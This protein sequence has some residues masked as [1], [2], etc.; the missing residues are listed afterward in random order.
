MTANAVEQMTRNMEARLSSLCVITSCQRRNDTT[1]FSW[2]WKNK[3]LLFFLFFFSNWFL[4]VATIYESSG[5]TFRLSIPSSCIF[6]ENTPRCHFLTLRYFSK[7]SM[8]HLKISFMQNVS[9][10]ISLVPKDPN[11]RRKAHV[12]IY[13][14]NFPLLFFFYVVREGKT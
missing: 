2:V 6:I 10:N 7:Q 12:P 4:I 13:L 9:L 8:S 14:L 3:A 11:Y 5:L 1:H